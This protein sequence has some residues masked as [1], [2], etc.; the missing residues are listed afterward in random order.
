[1]GLL[2]CPTGTVS[3]ATLD[4]ETNSGT[5]RFHGIFKGRNRTWGPEPIT[6]VPHARLGTCEAGAL[7]DVHLRLSKG[8]REAGDQRHAQGDSHAEPQVVHSHHLRL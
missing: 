8:L 7:Q 5:S 6:R 3:I 4:K 1:M 2:R